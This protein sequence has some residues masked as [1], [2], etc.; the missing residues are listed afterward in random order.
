MIEKINLQEKFDRFDV[1]WSPMIV[2][3]LNDSFVKLAKLKGEFVWHNH[4]DEDEMF[5]VVSGDLTILLRDGEVNLS[6]GEMV[7]IPKGVEH[8]PVAAEEVQVMLLELKT[9]KHTGQV[10]SELTKTV[11][12]W[13]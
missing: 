2:S 8:K 6:P 4:E 13:I 9:T 3:Q 10:E 11:E 7:I 12:E 5:F 1:L